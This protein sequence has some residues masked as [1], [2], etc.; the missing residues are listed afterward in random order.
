M[1]KSGNLRKKEKEEKK[2]SLRKIRERKGMPALETSWRILSKERPVSEEVQI[3][4]QTF[5]WF[6]NNSNS[7]NK[8][9]AFLA[10]GALLSKGDIHYDQLFY[11]GHICRPIG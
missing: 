7:F 8:S 11:S 6:L 10:S 1:E 3:S 9:K 2:E 4:L 5:L